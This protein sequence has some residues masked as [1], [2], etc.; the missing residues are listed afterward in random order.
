[1]ALILWNRPALSH[2]CRQPLFFVSCVSAT[3]MDVVTD[4]SAE[5]V[6]TW[7][8]GCWPS[9]GDAC[10]CLGFSG[11]WLPLHHEGQHVY[12]ESDFLRELFLTKPSKVWTF[13]LVLPRLLR[14]TCRS[15]LLFWHTEFIR[16]SLALFFC[17]L[18]SYLGGTVAGDKIVE[19]SKS[20]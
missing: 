8:V 20:D 16:M 17:L 10:T 5:S 9:H 18:V 19:I 11:D 14:L 7:C 2:I 6:F 1:M 4:M 15:A 13:L 12:E 3:D